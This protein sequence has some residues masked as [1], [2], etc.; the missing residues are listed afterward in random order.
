MLGYHAGVK[1]STAF[2]LDS[3]RMRKLKKPWEMVEKLEVSWSQFC[4][5]AS[6]HVKNIFRTHAAKSIPKTQQ[7]LVACV[8]FM[9]ISVGYI[10]GNPPVI[11]WITG[12]WLNRP[13]WKICLSKMGSSSPIFGVKKKYLQLPSSYF[14]GWYPQ[15]HSTSK[16]DKLRGEVSLQK[17][18]PP[19]VT[20]N[21]FP[22]PCRSHLVAW[23][24]LVFPWWI[25][26]RLVRLMDSFSSIP[27]VQS[28]RFVWIFVC[29][30]WGVWKV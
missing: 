6:S 26:M 14:L 25:V 21:P 1:S 28:L 18:T 20:L 7:T 19:W 24:M 5:D 8:Q 10:F 17:N 22:W 13:I 15:K 12:W 27:A 16:H 9:W 11:V 30:F 3:K 4:L 23:L 29:A 2:V